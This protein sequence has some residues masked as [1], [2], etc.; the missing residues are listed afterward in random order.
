MNAQQRRNIAMRR[1]RNAA[2][3][4]LIAGVI[5]TVCGP[6]PS[7]A[8]TEKQEHD[9]SRAYVQKFLKDPEKKKYRDNW[10]GCI[11][12]FLSAY[13]KNPTGEYA[14]ANL[15]WAGKLYQNL[16]AFSNKASDRKESVDIFNR[17]INRYPKSPYRPKAE[18][19]LQ[20]ADSGSAVSRNKTEDPSG[21]KDQQ[22][23]TPS[24][25]SPPAKSS[26]ENADDKTQNA[27][28]ASGGVGSVYLKERDKRFKQAKKA[29]KAAGRGPADPGQTDDPISRLIVIEGACDPDAFVTPPKKSASSAGGS[30][31]VING[32][33]FWSNPSYTRI[34]IYGSRET[35]SKPT[36][37]KQDLTAHKPQRLYIDFENSRLGR[38]L[39]KD[40]TIDDDLLLSA[41]AGQCTPDTVRVVIDIK[42]FKTYKIF[43][44][45]NPFRTIIDVWGK[46]RVDTAAAH[47]P[48]K[49]QAPIRH[50]KPLSGPKLRVT[51]VAV[52]DDP[53][54][55]PNDLAKQF[56]LVVRRIVIDAGH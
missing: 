41:R 18:A 38:D 25:P 5:G 52:H 56:A 28:T 55:T 45:N 8:D 37:L 51:E 10:V 33:R 32:L 23:D 2:A 34:A 20:S 14:A 36:M 40:I 26:G 30:H 54:I 12:K 1:I 46:D 13:R 17:L 53:S 19:A 22:R 44:L 39:K 3:F 43:S 48:E 42:S 11:Q 29:Y 24:K 21:D 7:L 49:K 31:A 4:L 50:K 35:P 27:Q 16:Y 47:A 15:Y 6:R 9:R